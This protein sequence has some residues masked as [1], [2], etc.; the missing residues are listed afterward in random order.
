[1]LN[2]FRL[3]VVVL[4]LLLL[5][6]T[7]ASAEAVDLADAGKARHSIVVSKQASPRVRAA[8]D[9][10]ASYLERISGAEFTVETGNDDRGIVVGTVAEFPQH[11]DKRFRPDDPTG[12]EDYRLRSHSSGLLLIGASDLAVEHAVW[13]LLYRLGHRQFFPGEHWEIVPRLSKLTIDVDAIERPDYYA[14][15]IWYGFGAAEWSKEHHQAWCARN[16]ATA[17]LQLN[18]GHTYEGI[19]KQHAGVFAEHPEYLALVDGVRRGP[20]FCLS[21]DQLRQLIIEHKL[22]QVADDPSVQSVSMDPSDG[23]GWCQCDACQRLGSVSDQAVG[24]ANDVAKAL[25]EKYG[26]KYVGIYAYSHHAPPPNVR[27]HPKLVVSV[28]TAFIK[29]DFTVDQLMSGWQKQGATLGVR[30]YLS[31]NTWD[32]DLPGQP[33][34]SSREYIARTIPHFNSQGARFYSAESSDNWG[35]NGLGYYLASRLLWDTEEAND[36]DALIDDFLEKG[37]A[38]AREPMARFYLLIDGSQKPLLSNNLLGRMY[39]LLDEA[40]KLETDPAVQQR[41][42]DLVLYTRYAELYSDYTSSTGAERQQ[43]FEHLLRHAYRMRGTMLVHT[44]ALYRDLANRDKSVTIPTEAAWR[45]PEGKNPWKSS[46]S[47]TSAEVDAQIVR[48]IERRQLLAFTPVSFSNELVPAAP[49]KLEQVQPGKF[50]SLTR[51][52]RQ[53]YTWLE[54]PGALELEVTAGLVYANQAPAKLSLF[55]AKETLGQAVGEAEVEGTKQPQLVRLSTEYAGLQRLEL[56]DRGKGTRIE[57]P[58]ALPITLPA[59]REHPA[60]F[61]GRWSL[62]FYVPK[63]TKTIGGYASAGAGD[64]LDPDGQKVHTFT[65]SAGYFQV[66]VGAGQDGK[67]WKFH[68]CAGDRILLTVPPYVARSADELLLP[69]EVVRADAAGN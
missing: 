65:K 6:P 30:E 14:R 31:V 40:R 53:F 66:P 52:E 15:R 33:R 12:A 38:G 3:T 22:K 63:G 43:A 64:L 32:R 59:T 56:S 19:L 1:M 26:D 50:G 46:E 37:F 60:N 16:R 67:L 25:E 68:N 24:I 23:G 36:I 41:I 7:A 34:G 17:G 61:N 5:T 27:V 55:S 29:G 39:R 57:W 47:F 69:A 21:N 42:A 20:K 10:L 8:A 49:L 54:S 2:H 48:G 28:A 4:S 18:T 44:Q 35:C 13:D 45:V 9:V 58:A 62:Y 11:A 51:G